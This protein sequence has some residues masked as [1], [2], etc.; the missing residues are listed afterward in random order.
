[1]GQAVL[2]PNL[3]YH[4]KNVI[5]TYSTSLNQAYHHT[6]IPYDR[7]VAWI[8]RTLNSGI[9]HRYLRICLGEP[10]ITF[11]IQLTFFLLACL[12][13]VVRNTSFC[14]TLFAMRGTATKGATQVSALG[15][16]RLGEKENP[17]MSTSLQVGSQVR[18]GSKG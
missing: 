14:G 7:L 12:C 6:D 16:G 1:M 9:L 18:A 2:S 15:I 13:A 5:P 8:F 3:F 11:T 17:A 10:E 4:A